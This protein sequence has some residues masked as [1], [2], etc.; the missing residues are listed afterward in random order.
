MALFHIYQ[1]LDEQYEST[2]IL[3]ISFDVNSDNNVV[4]ISFSGLLWYSTD[5]CI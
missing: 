2:V 5:K 4:A 3:A 1:F